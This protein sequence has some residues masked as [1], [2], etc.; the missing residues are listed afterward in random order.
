MQVLKNILNI[1]HSSFRLN[2]NPLILLFISRNGNFI[3]IGIVG[4]NRYFFLKVCIY[5]EVKNTE[6]SYVGV[7]YTDCLGQM[8][9]SFQVDIL[10]L[11]CNPT[12]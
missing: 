12:Y 1:T 11:R 6:S 10:I 2:F 5:K 4:I 7:G 9:A 3:K 8:S